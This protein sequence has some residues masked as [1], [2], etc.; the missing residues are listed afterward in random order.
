ME[1]IPKIF[2]LSIAV[3]LMLLAGLFYFFNETQMIEQKNNSGV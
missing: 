2:L 3:L 1:K